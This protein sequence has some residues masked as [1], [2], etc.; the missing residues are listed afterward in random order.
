AAVI[1]S[2]IR[3]R[4][5]GYEFVMVSNQDGLGTASFPVADFVGPQ[6]F[7]LDTL[8]SQGI[9]FSAIC[10]DPTFPSARAETRKPGIGLVRG[11]LT[12][13]RLD[14]E[15][16][17]VIGDRETDQAFAA[18]M[19]IRGFRVGP[20]GQTWPQIADELLHATRSAV[21]ERR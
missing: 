9:S 6:R 7:I 17:A 13:G 11:Y 5:A 3:L 16:S 8:Q 19:G 18:N 1:P 4:D 10:I 12:G 20:L 2:L 14:V 21:V 15:H